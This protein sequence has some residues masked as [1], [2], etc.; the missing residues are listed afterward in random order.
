MPPDDALTPR[1]RVLVTLKHE[2][3]DRI[4]IDFG[5]THVSTINP[6]CYR[7]LQRYLRLAEKPAR[8]KDVVAQLT[9][10][11]AELIELF[12][13]DLI[14]VNR[15]LPPTNSEVYYRDTFYQ[16]MTCFNKDPVTGKAEI[17]DP[18]WK[19]WKHVSYGYEIEIPE[20]IDIVEEQN[21]LVIYLNRTFVLGRGSRSSVTF[22]PPDAHGANPL[23]NVRSAQD[24]K[25][26]DWDVFKVSDRYVQFL[27][28]KAEYLYKNTNYALVFS[29]AG[30][31]HAWAQALRGWAKWLA[32]L[33]LRKPLAEAVLDQ[34]MDV[35]M[36]NIK[37]YIEAFGNHVHVIGFADDLG[38]EEGPQISVQMF[39]EM[40]KHRYEELFGYI[41]RH[42]KMYI[43]LHSDGSIFPLI[44]EFI[45]VG[46]DIINPIQLSAKGM[47]P[48]KLKKE[49]GEQ[50]TFWGGGADV[51]KVLPFAK[52]GE[53]VEHVKNLIKI[54]APGGGF[55][56]AAT[57]NI[58][59][60]TPPENIVLAFRTAYE[61]GRYPIR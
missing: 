40:Y 29:L 8:V 7:D 42:S 58:Q 50:I 36:Y 48:E 45:D 19:V 16:C 13:V 26:I 43:F 51:Q 53:V 10:V 20:S 15:H 11:D 61:Y 21:N 33:R 28:D 27:R 14:D 39:R 3:P 37:K 18:R 55:V 23:A 24:I 5:S 49:Y 1:E 59:P 25:N 57:H 54:F 35:L 4:P 38:T 9:E 41:K 44:K 6:M 31:L 12:N 34:I 52:P 47:E 22:S 46:L 56:F 60:P 17:Y 2:E 30:R 32:D